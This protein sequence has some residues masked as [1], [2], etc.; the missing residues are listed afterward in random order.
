MKIT[1]VFIASGMAF[2]AVLALSTF[3]YYHSPFGDPLKDEP[4]I[5][6]KKAIIAHPVSEVEIP[7]SERLFI[8][9]PNIETEHGNQVLNKLDQENPEWLVSDLRTISRSP[10]H[11]PRW[12]NY[13]I[14]HLSQH[15]ILYTDQYSYDAIIESVNSSEPMVRE[16]AVFSLGRICH[17]KEVGNNLVAQ[18]KAIIRG[19]IFSDPEKCDPE[20]YVRISAIRAIALA[21]WIDFYPDI[22]TIASNNNESIP[23][24]VAAVDALGNLQ[25][26]ESRELLSNLSKVESP[27][28]R[29]AAERALKKFEKL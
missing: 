18:A 7:D 20:P 22:V 19:M 25:V 17:E 1:N 29:L 3:L 11:Q 15:Y 12:R 28:L 5:V 13:C 27:N 8:N 9:N 10:N 23:V 21:H 2:S 4:T 16:V 14:Q 6:V 26:A 24:R